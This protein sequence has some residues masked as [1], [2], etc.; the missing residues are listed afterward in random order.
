MKHTKLTA[1]ILCALLLSACGEAAATTETTADTTTNAPDETTSIYTDLGTHDYGGKTFTIAYCKSQLGEM[2]PYEAAEENG[3]VVNDAV[4]KRDSGIEDKY[5]VDIVWYDTNGKEQVASVMQSS[6]MAGD[7]EYDLGIGHMFAGVNTLIEVGGLYDFNKLPV[8]DYSKPWWQQNLPETL[9]VDG[10]LLLNVSDLV[11]TFSDCIYFS[12][13]ML[14]DYS[15]LPDPYE[16][17][18]SGKWTW[19]VLTEMAMEVGADL[20]GDSKFDENDRYG[21]S[22]ST[23]P[24]VDANWIYANGMTIATI[25]NGEI[26]LANVQSERMTAT[27]EKMYK[28]VREGNHTYI[29]PGAGK[30]SIKDLQLFLNGQALFH[31]NITALLPQMRDAELDFGIVPVPKFDEAQENYYSMATTQMMMVPS[32]VT[33]T[34]FTGLMLEALSMESHRLVRPAV[35]ETSF[36]AKYLRDEQSYEMYNIIRDSGVYDF[37][38][39]FGSGNAFA[40]MMATLV[41][42]GSPDM[43]ASF[44][45]K[46]ETAVMEMLTEVLEQIRG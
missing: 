44:Y 23:N 20:N 12:K 6:I 37:N 8:V 17:V 46:N 25:E 2:W 7:N 24:Y 21:Y 11:Y 9:A 33:D 32:T 16:L 40:Q 43:L 41:R 45:A 15:S 1:W 34:E 27:L 29:A 5:N 14:A 38:W 19:D 4:W 42:K 22:M 10:I 39:N 18:K 26:S 3:D 31:E 13:D 35:Y 30:E 36:S 28:L